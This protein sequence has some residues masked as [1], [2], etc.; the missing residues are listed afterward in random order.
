[1]TTF[2]TPLNIPS[3]QQ[4]VERSFFQRH[5]L[6]VAERL[7]GCYL[8]KRLGEDCIAV[9]ITETEA[10]RG[11]DDPASHAHRK[12]TPR[13]RLMFGQSG[14]LYVYLTYGMHYCMNIVTEE[15]G[16]PGAVLLR[17]ARPIQGIDHIRRHRPGVPDAQLLNGPGKL[18]KGLGITLEHNGYD[19]CSEG[20][21]IMI[22]EGSL[23]N[24]E[25]VRTERIGIS[26]GKDLLWRFLSKPSRR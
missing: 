18:T 11:A 7:L 10:Y 13:N 16:Q 25:I 4:R 21:E 2:H 22:Y 1:M 26:Q 24:E 8:V 20:A 12:M 6:E 3:P 17:A 5:S 19:I 14:L 9:Q 15:E 23:K